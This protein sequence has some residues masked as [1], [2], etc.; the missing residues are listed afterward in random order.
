MTPTVLLLI[1]AASAFAASAQAHEG[2]PPAGATRDYAV[3]PGD[4]LN[5]RVYGEEPL[6]GI[7]PVND[8][9]ELNYPLLGRVPVAGHTADQIAAMLGEQLTGE[10]LVAPSITVWLDAHNSQ[11]VPVLGAVAEPGLY[12]LKGQTTVLELLSQAG[13]VLNGSASEVRITHGGD[14][15]NVT[16][17]PFEGLIAEGAGNQVLR[18]GD[19]VFVPDSLIAVMGSVG[20]PGEVPYREGLT[21]SQTIA[22]AGGPTT[23]ANLGRVYVLRGGQ[24]IRV[25]LRRALKGQGDDPIVQ[26]GD[27]IYVKESNF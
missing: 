19:L 11:P 3:G 12:Y 21:V 14:E 6:S 15:S 4:T 24:R 26:P 17:V 8:R 13:G 7:F 5:V 23:V 20:K 25:N 16:I 22:A 10:Y 27:R 1:T 9:G 2:S 18:A